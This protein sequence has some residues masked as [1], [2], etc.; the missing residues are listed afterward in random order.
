MNQTTSNAAIIHFPAAAGRRD[1][2]AVAFLPAALE[3]IESPPSPIG[4]A[5][6]FAI[7]TLSCF[8]LAW[9]AFGRIDI[10]ATAPGKIIASGRSKVIQPFETGIVRAIHVQDGQAVNAGEVLIQLDSTT[11][12]AE[13]QHV[14]SDLAAARLDVARLQ[15]LLDDGNPLANFH[16]P[17]DAPANLAAVQR[18]FL[19]DQA[20]EH[21]AKLA[22]LDRQREKT[23]AEVQTSAATI[24]KYEELLPIL[25]ERVEMKKALYERQTGS[26]ADYL[27]MLYALVEQQRNLAIEKSRYREAEAGAAAIVEARAQAV[28][29]FGRGLLDDLDRAEAKAAG[30]AQDAVKAEQRTQWQKLTAPVDGVVQQLAV[31][32]IGG[33]VTPAQNLL[34]LVPTD[35]HFEIEA[36]VS[37]RDIGF[38]HAGQDVAIKVDTFPFTR[39]GLLRGKVLNVSQDAIARDKPAQKAQ[40][41]APGADPSSSE[42]EGQELAYAARISLGRTQMRVDDKLVNLGPGM[43]V[44]VEV[45]TGTRT[46]LSYLLSPMMQIKQE[47]MQER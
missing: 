8:A 30:L 18:K 27:Q 24:G 41:R 40:D 3:I 47:S 44:T 13:L 28:A 35:S 15:A 17:I 33:V 12:E 1:A 39:Y 16:P 45:K 26:K 11:S 10:V 36:M 6:V 31:H 34:V 20:A 22:G 9:A 42:P 5:L 23:E 25:A 19:V 37:N 7:V 4:R 14:R 29:E 38:V 2:D 32:T 46:V 43:A 21:Q